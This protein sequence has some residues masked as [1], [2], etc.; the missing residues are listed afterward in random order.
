MTVLIVQFSIGNHPTGT[1]THSD[2][3][4]MFVPAIHNSFAATAKMSRGVCQFN[5]AHVKD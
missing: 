5:I 3:G 4:A 1:L 2:A